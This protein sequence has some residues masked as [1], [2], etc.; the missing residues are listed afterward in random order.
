MAQL[1]LFTL[2]FS[3]CTYAGRAAELTG[4]RNDRVL[5]VIVSMDGSSLEFAQIVL[6]LALPSLGLEQ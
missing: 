3:F 1:L 2:S 5:L 6:L 4:T